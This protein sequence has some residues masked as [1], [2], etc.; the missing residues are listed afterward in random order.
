[1]AWQQL[2]LTLNAAIPTAALENSLQ[3]YGALSITFIDAADDPI[4]EPTLGSVPLWQKTKLTA[5]FS[6]DVDVQKIIAQ[7]QT[8]YADEII[9]TCIE[10]LAEQDWQRSWLE[11]FKPLQFGKR[12]WIIPS[13]YDIPDDSAINIFLDPGLAF[14]SGTHPTTA[15]CL[16]WLAKHDVDNK[17]VIDYGC[18]SGILAIA[19]LKLQAKSVW[20]ID[21]DPQA[22]TATAENARRNQLPAEKLH[23]GQNNQL[24][25]GYQANI[26]I[27]N[28]L[29]KPLIEL[30]PLFAQHLRHDGKIVLSGILAKQKAAILDIYQQYFSMHVV[31][32]QEDWICLSGNK[33]L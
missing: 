18:G 30:A 5:L 26:I 33:K 31:A 14:G 25:N 8:L 16:A 4:F 15:M 24:P 27:A 11:Y 20:A 7:L 17:T 6:L 2:H 19:A 9:D 10:A 3:E 23:L 28:I 21:H 13:G 29:A 32:Q 22:L 1:M 12:L